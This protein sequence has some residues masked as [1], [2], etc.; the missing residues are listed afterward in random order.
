M[1]GHPKAGQ[2]TYFKERFKSGLKI[3]TMRSNIDYW[4]P[5]IQEV[6]DG[7]AR[8][9]V[10]E[11]TGK[12]Y[13]SQQM[14]IEDLTDRDG[15]GYQIARLDARNVCVEHPDHKKAYD[16]GIDQ[17]Y[18]AAND[19]LLWDDFND[20]MQLGDEKDNNSPRKDVVII[21]FT[22]FRY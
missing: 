11:W 3:H 4:V 10:R 18:A 9:S 17:I 13:A 15:V 7:D 2:P 14:L 16:C 1:Q 20:W 5:K 8:L 19:G 22:D 21:H 12:P 6:I